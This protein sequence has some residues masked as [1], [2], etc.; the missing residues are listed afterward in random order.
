MNPPVLHPQVAALGIAPLAAPADPPTSQDIMAADVVRHATKKMRVRHALATPLSR[1]DLDP[2]DLGGPG[3]RHR[4][5][6]D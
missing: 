5:R 3:C 4:S 1:L 2:I 6:F